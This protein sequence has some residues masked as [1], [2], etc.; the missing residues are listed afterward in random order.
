MIT[1]GLVGYG[2]MAWYMIS[3][4]LETR[5]RFAPMLQDPNDLVV[6]IYLLTMG[7]VVLWGLFFES[8]D[9]K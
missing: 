2:L 3:Q 9:K 5:W 6:F 8:R 7:M 4:D 1:G